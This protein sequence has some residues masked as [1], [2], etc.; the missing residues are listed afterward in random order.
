M[1]VIDYDQVWQ[2]LPMR[3]AIDAL[4]AALHA[5]GIPEV[6]AR[7]HL[8]HGAQELLLMPCFDSGA[9]GIK[10]VGIDADN[11]GRGLPRIHG[12]FVLLDAPGLVPAAL[13]DAR[14]LTAL[15]TAA[16]SGVATRHLAHHLTDPRRP[17]RL[18]VFGAGA[19]A[20]AHLLAMHAELPL[21]DVRIVSRSPGSAEQL[22]ELARPLLDVEVA[23]TG[24]EAVADAEVVC[25][26]TSSPTPVFDGGSL[27]PGVHLNAVGA[28]RPDLQELDATTVIGAEVVVETRE[29]A[30]REAGDLIAAERT[31]DWDRH[32]IRA[33]LT[34]L[35]RDGRAVRTAPHQ[36]TL[37]KSVG[38]AWE[39]LVVARAVLAGT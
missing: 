12:V 20:H 29:A 4:D 14:A 37:F 32:Q 19:Q 36:R 18:V 7:E 33:D 5:T 30:M 10:L 6:P 9:A 13:L 11:P 35:V 8:H 15:R 25:V 1:E 34:E 3:A 16:V 22:A 2:R 39:D 21:A 17:A 23:L 28:Y 27:L 38:L 31:G 26:C 24:P